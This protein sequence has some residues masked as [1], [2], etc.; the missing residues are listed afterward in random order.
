MAIETLK[1]A[2]VE[3][4]KHL[5]RGSEVLGD[6][7]IRDIVVEGSQARL[8]SRIFRLRLTYDGTTANAPN[9]IILKTGFPDRTDGLASPTAA[10]E[11]AFYNDV[12]PFMSTRL[13]PRCFGTGWNV[14]QTAWHL[15]LEDLTD[16]HFVATKVPFPPTMTQC[17]SIM[18]AQAHFHAQW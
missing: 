1:T 6:G 14:N 4:L 12:A 11:I 13:V 2:D 15:L 8:R 10:R 3:Y 7:H 16:S 5:L 9:F 18:E 17:E